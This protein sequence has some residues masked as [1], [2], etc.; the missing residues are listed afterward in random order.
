M[1]PERARSVSLLSVDRASRKRN[2]VSNVARYRLPDAGNSCYQEAPLRVQANEQRRAR[3]AGASLPDRCAQEIQRLTKAASRYARISKRIGSTRQAAR[4]Q[5][6][7]DRLPRQ[8]ELRAMRLE[9]R[10]QVFRRTILL[11]VLSPQVSA[12]VCDAQPPR[13]RLRYQNLAEL[14]GSQRSSFDD[15]L[16]KGSSEQGCDGQGELRRVGGSGG[17]KS[18]S[19]FPTFGRGFDPIVRSRNLDD[20]IAL[21]QLSY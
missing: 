8:A 17:L 10:Q 7:A 15:G 19:L 12:Y 5:T 16:P 18:G 1:R 14:D 21:T 6:Q 11:Q 20:S 2:A 13:S 9:A 4:I 3:S